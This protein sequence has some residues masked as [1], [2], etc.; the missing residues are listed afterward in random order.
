MQKGE[1]ISKF[2]IGFTILLHISN[3]SRKK[4]KIELNI[5]RTLFILQHREIEEFHIVLHLIL[6]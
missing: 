1:I 2:V 4:R 3:H 5:L 6:L